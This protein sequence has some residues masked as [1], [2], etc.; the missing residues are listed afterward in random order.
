LTT[1]EKQNPRNE[2]KEAKAKLNHFKILQNKK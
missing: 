2:F 1:S